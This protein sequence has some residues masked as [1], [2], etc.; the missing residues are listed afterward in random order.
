M[1]IV[2]KST[3]RR[4]GLRGNHEAERVAI[5]STIVISRCTTGERWSFPRRRAFGVV[6][7]SGSAR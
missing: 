3:T 1:T 2:D 5:L 4:S 6:R 7:G